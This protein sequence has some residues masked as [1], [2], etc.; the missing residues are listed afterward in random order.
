MK[1]ILNL[2]KK[3][4]KV[5]K[6]ISIRWNE[7]VIDDKM[8]NFGTYNE[9]IFRKKYFFLSQMKKFPLPFPT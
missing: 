8:L 5:S 3:Q 4:L 9:Y 7:R 1:V 2:I 6:K